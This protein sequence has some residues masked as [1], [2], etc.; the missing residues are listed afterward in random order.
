MFWH[1]FP[2]FVA[3]VCLLVAVYQNHRLRRQ[4]HWPI[5]KLP[6]RRIQE[7]ASEAV[8]SQLEQRQPNLTKAT[9]AIAK[10]KLAETTRLYP[11][12]SAQEINAL[13]QGLNKRVS[14]QLAQEFCSG[15]IIPLV[16]LG[17]N[18]YSKVFELAMEWSESRS[19]HKTLAILPSGTIYA[20]RFGC[21]TT[22][23]VQDSPQLRTIY[24]HDQET[25]SYTWYKLSLPYLIYVMV[26][27]GG[28]LHSF[29]IGCRSEPVYLLTDKVQSI[30]LPNLD[31]TGEACMG[32]IDQAVILNPYLLAPKM[33][34]SFWGATFNDDYVLQTQGITADPRLA[35]LRNWEDASANDPGF[36]MNCQ[37]YDLGSLQQLIDSKTMNAY[38]ELKIQPEL[39]FAREIEKV[40]IQAKDQFREQINALA[41]LLGQRSYAGTTEDYVATFAES[42]LQETVEGAVIEA[43]S[44]VRQ[45]YLNALREV[46]PCGVSQ[47]MNQVVAEGGENDRL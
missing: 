24:Y 42:Y 21:V 20:H 28:R 8:I 14:E 45:H 39:A 4:G 19:P 18:L 11:G 6:L 36:I 32:G 15:L 46:V 43:A 13:L 40:A 47:A 38:N 3:A 35:T 44:G 7:L 17:E 23:V 1:Y 22:V 41:N 37:L 12:I 30:P 31:D 34:A 10:A 26:F 25:D 9:T 16:D 2:W 29:S 5:S 27:L 33:I